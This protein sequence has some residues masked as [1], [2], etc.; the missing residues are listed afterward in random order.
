MLLTCLKIY[1]DSHCID[2]ATRRGKLS[3]RA[4]MQRARLLLC[5]Q[6]TSAPGAESPLLVSSTYIIAFHVSAI[7]IVTEL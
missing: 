7:A 6:A 2:Y 3:A 5:W 4:L 1:R